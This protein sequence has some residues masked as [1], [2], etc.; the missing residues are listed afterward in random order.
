MRKGLEHQVA[1]VGSVA[2]PPKRR[3]REG[4]GRS[5]REIEAALRRELLVSRV[6]EAGRAGSDQPFVLP[7]AGGSRLSFPI[8]TSRSSSGEVIE[9]PDQLELR[10]GEDSNDE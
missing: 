2:V 6:G 7:A 5:V 9:A 8:S 4:M 10:A 1:A 3:Q